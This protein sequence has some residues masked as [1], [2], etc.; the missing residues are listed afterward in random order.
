MSWVDGAFAPDDGD[1]N[2]GKDSETGGKDENHDEGEREARE[3]HWARRVR[4]P[5]TEIGAR[6]DRWQAVSVLRSRRRQQQGSGDGQSSSSV[7]FEAGQPVTEE[8][9]VQWRPPEPLWERFARR[10]DAQYWHVLGSSDEDDED[11]DS[12]DEF[13]EDNLDNLQD[14]SGEPRLALG[15]RGRALVRAF[16]AAQEERRRRGEEER[17]QARARKQERQARMRA[18]RDG[19]VVDDAASGDVDSSASDDS[20]TH[21]ASPFVEFAAPGRHT[22]ARASRGAAAASEAIQNRLAALS[23]SNAVLA[24]GEKHIPPEALDGDQHPLIHALRD[25]QNTVRLTAVLELDVISHVATYVITESG[26]VMVQQGR[27]AVQTFGGCNYANAIPR[28]MN[29]LRLELMDEGGLVLSPENLVRCSPLVIAPGTRDCT[30]LQVCLVKVPP[31]SLWSA[32]KA[33]NRLGRG[34]P[35]EA[36]LLGD[37]VAPQI[38]AAGSCIVALPLETA[39]KAEWRSCDKTSLLAL[40]PAI[41]RLREGKE[42]PDLLEVLPNPAN[43]PVRLMRRVAALQTHFNSDDLEPLRKLSVLPWCP[44]LWDEAGRWFTKSASETLAK[45]QGS[46]DS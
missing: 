7:L 16:V 21:R 18:K 31:R 45:I 40:K 34:V 27:R 35:P 29:S 1:F 4:V 12:Q 36:G 24:A 28:M 22:A 46:A 42:S 26:N 14:G 43:T 23:L 33:R 5:E 32:E 41:A 39:H 13:P 38:K 3:E 20:V 11:E 37:F 2:E 6:G 44:M 25:V 19:V 10:G 17:I 30:L 9:L 15:D 8:F